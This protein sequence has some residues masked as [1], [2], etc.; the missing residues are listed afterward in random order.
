MTHCAKS[1]LPLFEEPEPV[2][3]SPLGDFF[4]LLTIPEAAHSPAVTSSH[5][6]E[7]VCGAVPPVDAA[8]YPTPTLMHI[9]EYFP[10]I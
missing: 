8:L 10:C 1:H 4:M 5:T 6:E 9:S 7:S 3:E 2:K